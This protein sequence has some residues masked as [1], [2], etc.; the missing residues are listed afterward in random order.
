MRLARFA[1]AAAFIATVPLSALATG[2]GSGADAGYDYSFYVPVKLAGIPARSV[3][4]VTCTAYD[5]AGETGQHIAGKTSVTVADTPLV[6]NYSGH[7]EIAIKPKFAI[8]SY[9]CIMTI[10]KGGADGQVINGR[11]DGTSFTPT[12]GWT[13]TMSVVKD[14]DPKKALPDRIP[15]PEH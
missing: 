14:L 4:T 9:A 11:V 2:T 6:V 10:A 5:T 13:G 15:E 7:L 1:L 8:A 3:A 12:T